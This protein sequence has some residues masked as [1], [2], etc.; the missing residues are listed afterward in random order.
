M[1]E[2]GRDRLVALD[3]IRGIAV[4][5]I[6]AVNIAGFAGPS[7]ATLSPHI[8]NPGSFADEAA[9]AGIFLIF[10]GKMRAL[11]SLLFGASMVLFIGRTEGAGESGELRQLRRLGWLMIFGLLHYFLFWWGDILFTYAVTGVIALAMRDLP[12]RS[13]LASALI[14]FT[15]WHLAGAGQ[16][17]SHVLA[18]EAVRT[19]T[20]TRDQA[21]QYA[22]AREAI[23]DNAASEM[24]EYRSGYF[25]QI[26]AKL[27]ERPFRPIEM[28]FN[29]IGE[30]LPLILIGMALQR[31]GLF[32]GALPRRQLRR[33]GMAWLA[34]GAA[35]T[36]AIL[37]WTWSRHFPPLAMNFA[38]LYWTAPGHLAMALGYA[39]VLV[40]AAPRLVASAI[41]GWIV[42]AGRMAFSNYLGTTVLMT[43]LF[44][45]WGLGWIG[46]F[47]Q[48][49]LLAFVLLGWAAMLLFSRAWLSFFRQGPLEWLW[50]SLTEMRLVALRA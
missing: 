33:W 14:L 39:A 46:Q 50:R 48:T 21:A 36:A 37:A 35:W 10:E 32:A 24:R 40:L 8:P 15:A 22:Q 45:G 18:E 20:P 42:R 7:A 25:D 2:G 13:L 47:G 4:L 34:F 1:H 12:V 23:V 5:G 44:Y 26:A 43:A 6:L 29:S 3:L 11:F 16:S 17:L 38:L 30:T 27:Q 49:E 41:G 28:V 31:L 9:Y 19:G